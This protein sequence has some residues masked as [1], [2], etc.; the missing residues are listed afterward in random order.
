V[1]GG[2]WAER[3]RSALADR[4]ADRI[5]ETDCE[6][7]AAVTLI[8]RPSAV[9]GGG[10]EALLVRRAEVPGDPWSGHVA[11]PGG[12]QDPDDVDLLDTAR[13]ETF[14]ETELRLERD[15]HLGR[16]GEIHPRSR[17]LPS[18]CVTPF[19]A[20]MAEHQE[21]RVNHELTGHIWVPTVAL[22]DPGYRST[23][24]LQTPTV[25]EFPAID[26][27]GHVIWGLTF[28]ILEDFLTVLEGMAESRP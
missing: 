5:P 27:E 19:V 22:S 18:I 13:R 11:L 14:E 2:E 10:P 24:V 7:R 28:A 20:W 25:R 15:D 21:V 4:P 6:T 26:F 16:L 8:L 9:D 12:R 23:L 3:L 17:H 1:T